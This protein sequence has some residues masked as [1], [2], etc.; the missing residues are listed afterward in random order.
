QTPIVDRLA[1]RSNGN[2]FAVGQY[3]RALLDQGLL[4][5]TAEGWK[6]ESSD[7]NDVVL[8]NDVVALL[9]GRV[10]SLGEEAE[11]TLCAAAVIGFAFDSSLLEATVGQGTPFVRRGLD[12][13]TRANLVEQLDAVRYQFIHDRV[14]EAMQQRLGPEELRAVNQATAAAIEVLHG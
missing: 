10:A 2:P 8:S 14:Q 5:P 4:R 12:E 13:A 6:I 11:K 1:S 7:L 9:L 3:I